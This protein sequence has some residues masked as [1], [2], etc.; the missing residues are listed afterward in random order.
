MIKNPSLF[1][2]FIYRIC[3]KVINSQA[4]SNRI[5]HNRINFER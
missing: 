5:K 1:L 3:E 4:K 2:K